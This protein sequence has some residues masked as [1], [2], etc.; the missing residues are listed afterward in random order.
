MCV[1]IMLISTVSQKISTLKHVSAYRDYNI[2]IGISIQYMEKN[3]SVVLLGDQKCVPYHN[4]IVD[5][6]NILYTLRLN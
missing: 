6:Y 3:V 2:K 5:L 1:N 4:D